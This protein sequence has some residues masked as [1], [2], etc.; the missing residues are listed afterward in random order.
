MK[1]Y[2]LKYLIYKSTLVSVYYFK[3]LQCYNT[4]IL[5]IC[6]YSTI[7]AKIFL[8]TILIWMNM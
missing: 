8:K 3:H 6:G 4:S 1:I 5:I 7:K 2:W